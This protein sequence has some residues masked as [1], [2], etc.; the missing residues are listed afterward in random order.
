MRFEPRPLSASRSTAHGA[1]VLWPLGTWA[2]LQL[3]LTGLNFRSYPPPFS[4]D[5]Q[6]CCDDCLK[7]G[8][9]NNQNC[10]ML[11]CVWQLCTMIHTHTCEQSLNLRVALGLDFLYVCLFRLRNLCIFC[12]SLDHSV[13][14]V[15]AF[16]VL[17][18]VSPIPGH[19]VGW[20]ESLLNYFVSVGM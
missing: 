20:E 9:G 4:S 10:S 5:R 1:R 15:L 17:D 3:C 19:N 13:P 8:I 7:V 14:V 2:D 12:F 16:V 11:C 6:L 18:L